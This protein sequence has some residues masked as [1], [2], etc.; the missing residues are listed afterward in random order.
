MAATAGS[1]LWARCRSGDAADSPEL[2]LTMSPP[3]AQ[4]RGAR[5]A[6][7]QSTRMGQTMYVSLGFAPVGRYEEWVSR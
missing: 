2:S 3:D 4:R 6:T 5:T 1:T 7:L